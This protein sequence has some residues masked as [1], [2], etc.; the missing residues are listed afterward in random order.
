M[1]VM[2]EGTTD[3]WSSHNWI[4][5][6]DWGSRRPPFASGVRS[7]PQKGSRCHQ[8][9]SS[10]SPDAAPSILQSGQKVT[11]L[12]LHNAEDVIFNMCQDAYLERA[13]L[14]SAKMPIK[15]SSRIKC[16]QVD[17]YYVSSFSW[18]HALLPKFEPIRSF[19]PEMKREEVN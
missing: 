5:Y 2:T 1:A 4:H 15:S 8:F 18:Y 7:A 11:C 19:I 9:L 10:D 6:E 3:C 16:S 14:H 17:S 13:K 12:I